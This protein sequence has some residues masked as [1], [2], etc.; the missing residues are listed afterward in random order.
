MRS[1]RFLIM[2]E[3]VSKTGAQSPVQLNASGTKR[4]ADEVCRGHGHVG[5]GQGE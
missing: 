2:Q 4:T 1:S 3:G 5:Q